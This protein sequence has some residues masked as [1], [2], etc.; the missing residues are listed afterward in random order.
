LISSW[1][2]VHWKHAALALVL[3]AGF[4][5]IALDPSLRVMFELQPLSAIDGFLLAF[6]ALAWVAGLRWIWRWD[7]L[8]RL[9]GTSTQPQRVST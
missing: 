1:H 9:L 5:I 7:L 6:V 2:D 4:S 3:M 8:A